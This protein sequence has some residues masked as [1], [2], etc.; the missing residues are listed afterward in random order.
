MKPTFGNSALL[1]LLS[2]MLRAAHADEYILAQTVRVEL[3]GLIQLLNKTTKCRVTAELKTRASSG[4]AATYEVVAES[5]IC[6]DSVQ[7]EVHLR[8]K[9]RPSIEGQVMAGTVIEMV[10]AK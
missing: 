9:L 5:E 1:L 10:P 3:P 7:R 6:A 8:G 2:G 4:N